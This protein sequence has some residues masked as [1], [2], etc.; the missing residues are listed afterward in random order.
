MSCYTFPKSKIMNK[1]LPGALGFHDEVGLA[2]PWGVS[3]SPPA[4]PLIPQQPSAS[5]RHRP[6]LPQTTPRT[7][8]GSHSRPQNQA[9]SRT[10]EG[11]GC[12]PHHC[13]PHTWRLTGRLSPLCWS[14]C[15]LYSSLWESGPHLSRS[16]PLISSCIVSSLWICFPYLF[17]SLGK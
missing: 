11:V 9:T 2:G 14:P 16:H 12:L 1:Y 17:I 7:G 13:R 15:G 10:P 5:L 4:P 3:P 6:L 8:P